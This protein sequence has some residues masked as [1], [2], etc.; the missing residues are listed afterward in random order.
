MNHEKYLKRCCELAEESVEKGNN[1]FGAL[2]VDSEGKIIIESGNIEM[3]EKDITGHAE[4]AVARLAGKRYSKKFLWNTTLYSTAE[5]CCMCTGAIYWA[6]IG[7]IVYGI[8]EKKL[9]KL[10]GDNEINPTF[11]LPCKDIIS[12]GQKN[13]EVVGPA[14]TKELEDLIVKPHIG[15]WD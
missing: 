8:S 15:F 11:D 6:N 9:L 2:L 13:I 4:T 10:T 1:P 5:P 3:T 7:R 14:A 12:K